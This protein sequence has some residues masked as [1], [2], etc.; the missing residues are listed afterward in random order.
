MPACIHSGH[1]RFVGGQTRAGSRPTALDEVQSM[2]GVLAG[3]LY[4]V[5]PRVQQSLASVLPLQ[6]QHVPPFLRLCTWVGGDRDGNPHVNPDVTRA[7]AR[8]A[9]RAILRRYLDA[10]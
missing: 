6:G 1:G 8:M 4:D 10:V 9:R 5:A 2:L 7:A 3:A